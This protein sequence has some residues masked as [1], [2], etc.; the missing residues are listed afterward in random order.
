MVEH[1]CIHTRSGFESR[2]D[3]T[4]EFIKSIKKEFQLFRHKFDPRRQQSIALTEQICV[5]FPKFLN[6]LSFFKY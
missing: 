3:K 6:F 4:T 1:V 2:L 5:S